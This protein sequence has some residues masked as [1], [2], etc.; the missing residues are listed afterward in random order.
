[1]TRSDVTLCFSRKPQILSFQIC[2]HQ[3]V[4]LTQKP[5]RL[6]NMATD[7]EMC[8]GLHCTRHMSATPET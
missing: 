3:T 8:V 1:M 5:G 4:R 2:V 6:Q 7:A